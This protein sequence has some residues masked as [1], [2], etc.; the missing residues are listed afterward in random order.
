MIWVLGSIKKSSVMSICLCGRPGAVSPVDPRVL[1]CV[2]LGKSHEGMEGLEE[3]VT[4]SS[5]RRKR[6]CLQHG[7]SGNRM[8]NAEALR[9]SCWPVLERK[10]RRSK[11]LSCQ[12]GPHG[13]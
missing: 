9:N 8:Y 2:V 13:N 7:L 1:E 4:S 3:A 5:G 11:D 12:K 10:E 6:A